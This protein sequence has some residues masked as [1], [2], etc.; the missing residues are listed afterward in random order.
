[1][2]T[3]KLNTSVQKMLADT[4][5]PVS[6]YL[7]LRDYFVNTI[8]LESSDYHGNENAFTYICCEPIAR[9]EATTESVKISMPGNNIITKEIESRSD[10]LD[11]L[12]QFSKSFDCRP[13]NGNS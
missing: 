5:T 7:Q 11:L 9:F 12:N 1:M 2:K 6:I 8:L 3:Y 13:A 4:F 10:A